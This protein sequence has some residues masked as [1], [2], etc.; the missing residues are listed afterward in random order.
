MGDNNFK[1]FLGVELEKGSKT[2]LTQEIKKLTENDIKLKV[3]LDESSLKTLT[4]S[5]DN[6]TKQLQKM[7][8]IGSSMKA[9][10]V[11]EDSARKAK[12]YA[13]GLDILT[14]SYKKGAISAR[15]YFDE[16]NK[17]MRSSKTGELNAYNKQLEPEKLQ[18]YLSLL[19]NIQQ[20]IGELKPIGELVSTK[21]NSTVLNGNT[22]LIQT[23]N[24]YADKMGRVQSITSIVNKETGTLV[25]SY[26]TITNKSEQ[27]ATSI[28][29]QKTAMSNLKASVE[30]INKYNID[31]IKSGN[32]NSSDNAMINQANQIKKE[33]QEINAI[34]ESGKIIDGARLEAFKRMVSEQQKAISLKESE[35]AKDK[36]L[37]QSIY[38]RNRLAKQLQDSFNKQNS[39]YSTGVNE[40]EKQNMQELINEYSK[41]DVAK[42]NMKRKNQE[43]TDS[44]NKYNSM[45]KENATQMQKE[46]V[47]LNKQ[48]NTLEKLKNKLNNITNSTKGSY[49][50]QQANNFTQEIEAI[51][52]LNPLTEE[53]RSRVE[54]ITTAMN[55]FGV[56]SR[57]AFAQSKGEL[58]SYQQGFERLITLFRV[59]EISDQQFLKSAQS[60]RY[61]SDAT[62]HLVEKQEYLN[63]SSQ[64][65]IQLSNAVATAQ[66][67]V[68]SQAKK[69]AEAQ[70]NLALYQEKMVFNLNQLKQ[71][72]SKNNMNTS[73]IDSMISRVQSLSVDTENLKNEQKKLNEEYRQMKVSASAMDDLGSKFK[74]MLG[75]VTGFYGLYS[76]FD[77]VR[78]GMSSVIKETTALDSSMIDL[79]R[80]TSES[81]STYSSF[82]N[83]MFSVANSI[84][85][86]AK[87][88]V[89][90]TTEFSKLGYSFTEASK[91]AQDASKYATTGWLSMQE[92]TDALSAS[93]TVF[94]GKLDET[95]GKV[96]DS[97][98]VID[99]YN[100]IGKLY[101]LPNCIVICNDRCV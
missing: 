76:V 81:Q 30:E 75:A 92:A 16:M 45:V 69:S 27:Y 89:D 70:Q 39:D 94:G 86:T 14:E 19:S 2:T 83:E 54:A 47:A 10:K 41:L 88:L 65:M 52:R 74:N 18:E 62:G 87:E 97:T 99:L 35:L 11:F 25:A 48:I 46:E 91:L 15:T 23:V 37:E 56:E 77:K 67:R 63:L 34:N 6:I 49:N 64:Q 96:V 82:K 100:K 12:D 40:K 84:G 71:A 59:G 78:E 20:R 51:S 66:N 31:L 24:T 26:E 5:I 7:T 44:L 43:I 22:E 42:E 98:T 53:Y 9:P 85:G 32:A 13:D 79:S 61:A 101:V 93:Y 80:V 95:I 38:E 28:E 33:F 8:T 50:K 4:T 72:Y 58:T 29:K 21:S 90:S 17:R 73:G 3:G 1:I 55:Q 60:I 57:N 36:Q 68:Q